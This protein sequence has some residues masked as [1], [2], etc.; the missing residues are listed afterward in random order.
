MEK[1]IETARRQIQEED[2][3]KVILE[4]KELGSLETTEASRGKVQERGSVWDPRLWPTKTEP[5]GGVPVALCVA[6][7]GP[8]QWGNRCS[9][10]EVL[11]FER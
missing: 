9:R 2:L 3:V 11:E 7:W 1:K 6:Q 8:S 4:C 10:P 5:G